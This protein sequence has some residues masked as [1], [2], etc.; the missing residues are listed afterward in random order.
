MRRFAASREADDLEH[1]VD[2][3]PQRVAGQPVRSSGQ[4]EQLAAGH[5]AV[6]A[7][8]LAEVA[9]VARQLEA[10]VGDGDAGHHGRAAG[11][12]PE[13]GQQAQ[14]RRLAGAVGTQEAEDGARR[15]GQVEA[16]EGHD[17]PVV[18]G[19][20][21]RLDGRRGCRVAGRRQ[22]PSRRGTRPGGDAHASSRP[23]R[24]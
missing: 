2:A 22:R 11:G 3:R 12:V 24:K 20:A 18:L 15:D 1:L 6:E 19:Q 23:K 8:L 9:D 16:I 21:A 7:R 14:R 4:L 17:R 13:A 10:A 5:P